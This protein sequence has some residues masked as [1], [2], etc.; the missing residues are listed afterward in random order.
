MYF[1][2]YFKFN[3]QNEKYFP[4]KTCY[5]SLFPKIVIENIKI[6]LNTTN[7][8]MLHNITYNVIQLLIN[9]LRITLFNSFYS[10]H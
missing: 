2:E 3:L 9:K 7:N 1:S 5:N 10:I 6:Q 8:S 4:N